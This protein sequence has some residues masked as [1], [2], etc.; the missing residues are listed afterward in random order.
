[1]ESLSA[2]MILQKHLLDGGGQFIWLFELQRDSSNTSYYTRE[3][4]D[5]TFNSQAYT[6]KEIAIDPPQYDTGGTLSDWRISLDNAD[7][8]EIA[9]LEAGKYVGQWVTVR[10]VN[11]EILSATANQVVLRGRIKSATADERVVVFACGANDWR[12]TPI[13]RST[14]NA[15]RCRWRF[16]SVECGYGGGQSTCDLSYDT[17]NN[18]MSNVERF[19]GAPG[20]PKFRP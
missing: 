10:I 6:S 9:Y 5:V 14:M 16:K 12:R 13:P 17:C 1:M 11:R 3:R 19:G 15:L 20:M 2:A 8:V 4:A 18:T 7:R